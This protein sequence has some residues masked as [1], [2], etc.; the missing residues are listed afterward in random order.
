MP[1]RL[2]K[3]LQGTAVTSLTTIGAFFVWTKHCKFE[4]LDPATDPTFRNTFYKKFKYVSSEA[5]F[6]TNFRPCLL[7][8][9][10]SQNKRLLLCLV[11]QR[12]SPILV[13]NSHPDSPQRNTKSNNTRCLR[14]TDPNFQDTTRLDRGCCKGWYEASRR[15]LCRRLGRLWYVLDLIACFPLSIMID[16][17]HRLHNPTRVS[18]RQVQRLRPYQPPALVQETTLI[19]QLRARHRNNRPF[20]RA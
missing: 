17:I 8:Q 11:S 20:Y 2:S 1:S 13:L 10:C 19:E 3:L 16:A 15:L 7:S 4:D 12:R 18:S 9:F 14:A 6:V 5:P